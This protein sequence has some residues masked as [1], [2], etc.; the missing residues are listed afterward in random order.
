ML[1]LQHIGVQGSMKWNR[2]EWRYPGP[3][4][5][6]CD[7]PTEPTIVYRGTDYVIRGWKCQK[8]HKVILF[9]NDLSRALQILKE[10]LKI[11]E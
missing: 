3:R 11:W 1:I 6:Y 8:C 4:C 10:T 5:I 9:P 7:I 2:L